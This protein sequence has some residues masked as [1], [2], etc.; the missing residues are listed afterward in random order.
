MGRQGASGY[1]NVTINVRVPGGLNIS[2]APYHWKYMFQFDF[3]PAPG[4]RWPWES[5]APGFDC[6]KPEE[7]RLM[8]QAWPTTCMLLKSIEVLELEHE[9]EG[10]IEDGLIAIDHLAKEK[11]FEAGGNGV[12]GYSVQAHIWE[13]P[14]KFKAV[15]TIC[16]VGPVN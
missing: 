10:T 8:M 2:R 12:L 1:Y 15:G 16:R 4:I 14:M 3:T 5:D 7:V 9:F 13:R 11:A 6:E